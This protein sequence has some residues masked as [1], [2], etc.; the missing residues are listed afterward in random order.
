[1]HLEDDWQRQT[2]QNLLEKS[3]ERRT[4]FATDNERAEE[5]EIAFYKL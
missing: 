1:M 2:L 5:P 3:S 4:P